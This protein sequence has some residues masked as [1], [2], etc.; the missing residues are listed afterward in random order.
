MGLGPLGKPNA[1]ANGQGLSV[2]LVPGVVSAESVWRG[3]FVTG[4]K[5]SPSLSLLLTKLTKLAMSGRV[6]RS[7]L[8]IK[9]SILVTCACF[10]SLVLTWDRRGV[11]RVE[12]SS[13]T[14]VPGVVGVLVNNGADA[15]LEKGRV[16]LALFFWV[17]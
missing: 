4:G 5:S 6:V 8:F 3:Y 13:C 1:T 15:S 10:W 7:G 11:T 17:G 9:E 2:G 12:G 16:L 14:G